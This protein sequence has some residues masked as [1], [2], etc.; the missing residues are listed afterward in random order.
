MIGPIIGFTETNYSIAEEGPEV[1][2]CAE[3]LVGPLSMPIR[4]TPIPVQA[5]PGTTPPTATENMDYIT[6]GSHT[7][8]FQLSTTGAL[9]TNYFIN[10]DAIYEEDETFGLNLQLS[11]SLSSGTVVFLPQRADI[12]IIDDDCKS[13]FL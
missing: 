12:T 8:S 11:S 6:R 13:L 4:V 7:L 5:M 3:I 9:C 1:T 2:V 10:S